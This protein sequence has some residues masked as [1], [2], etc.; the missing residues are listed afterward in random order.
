MLE[1]QFDFPSQH[2]I[3]GTG[4]MEELIAALSR[5]LARLVKE[6]HDLPM[7]RLRV[8][9]ALPLSSALSQARVRRHSIS[10]VRVERPKTSAASSVVRPPKNRSSTIRLWRGSRSA[11]LLKA[12]SSAMRSIMGAA[13]G[14]AK[15]S[16]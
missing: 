6:G 7:S 15:F 13:V 10:I 14:V 9:H 5:Q 2:R 1:Q 16:S 11:S 12:S 4:M 8:H 3:V